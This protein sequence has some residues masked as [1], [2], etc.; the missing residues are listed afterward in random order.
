[1]RPAWRQSVTRGE[2]ATRRAAN[3]A[4]PGSLVASEDPVASACRPD[5]E[6]GGGVG[7]E[8]GGAF[9][10]VVEAQLAQIDAGQ[11]RS[12]D[13][14]MHG[15]KQVHGVRKDLTRSLVPG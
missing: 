10:V 14:V 12:Q 11:H 7:F 6:T 2:Q 15:R 8:I 5:A 1:M 3:A 13:P 9:I 4:R